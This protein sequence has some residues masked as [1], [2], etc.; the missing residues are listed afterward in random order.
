MTPPAQPT[1]RDRRRALDRLRQLAPA[2]AIRDAELNYALQPFRGHPPTALMCANATCTVPFLWAGLD[3]TTARVQFSPLGPVDGRWDPA[4]DESAGVPVAM[5]GEPLLRWRFDCGRCRRSNLLSNGRL[6]TLILT[7][8]ASG[9]SEIT[10][11][12]E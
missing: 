8:L 12:A 9:R 5:P 2:Q 11:A 4:G 6:L 7:A 10:P 1:D 3:P